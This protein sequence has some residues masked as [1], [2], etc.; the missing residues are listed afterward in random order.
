MDKK[1]G[2]EVWCFCLMPNHVHLIVVP[3]QEKS[4]HLALR[5]T[6]RRYSSHINLREGWSGYLWQGRFCSYPMDEVHTYNAIH[7]IEENPVRAGLAKTT[8][9]WRWCSAS[10]RSNP[11]DLPLTLTEYPPAYQFDDPA[12]CDPAIFEK[13]ANTGRP[14][15]NA[16]FIANLESTYGRILAPQKSGR[17]KATT[18]HSET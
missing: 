13:H 7:Y 8:T 11:S 18:Q 17:K 6:H 14:L 9:E 12:P 10:L 2:L 3:L 1:A 16:A 5:E 15:G 4:L